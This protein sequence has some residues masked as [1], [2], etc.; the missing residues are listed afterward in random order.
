MLEEQVPPEI[1][2]QIDPGMLETLPEGMTF[3]ELVALRVTL[4]AAT[5][6]KPEHILGAANMILGFQAKPDPTIP[7]NKPEP[8]R[9]PPTEERRKAVAD[10][11]G[12]TDEK[13][14]GPLQ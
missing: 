6:K 9:L 10:Q 4:L 5:A 1:L 2:A 13:P 12:V 7:P 14:N 3:A 11:L 8:P